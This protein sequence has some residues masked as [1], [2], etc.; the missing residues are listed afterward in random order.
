MKSCFH[1]AALFAAFALYTLSQ[2]P[3]R[4]DI[5]RDA[6]AF[7]PA[8]ASANA[9]TGQQLVYT[10]PPA[11]L[12]QARKLYY[13]RTALDFVFPLWSILALLAILTLGW[14]AR[15]R[16]W[17]A[18]L[19]AKKWLQ[20]LWFAPL[21]LLLLALL[22]L[23]PALVAHHVSLRY[24]QSIQ[25]WPSWFIDWIKG[26]AIDLVSGTFVFGVLFAIIRRSRRWWLWFWIVSLPTQ[27]FV[28]FVLPVVIDPIFNHF[29]PLAETNPELVVQLERVV[30][31]AGVSIPPSRMFLMKASEKVTGS[32]AYVTGFGASKRVVV[33]DTTIKG[34]PTGEILSIFGHEL[35]HYVLNHIQRGLL[36][37]SALSL[38][39]LWLGSHLA[40]FLVRRWGAR[41]GIASLEDWGAAALLL[42]VLAVLNLLVD[43][44]SNSI[45]RLQE[46]QADVFGLEV[47]HGLV[48]DPQRTAAQ[49]FQRLGEESLDYPNPNPF[50]VFWTYNHPS[51]AAREAFA[52]SYDPWKPG[53][54]PRYFKDR[55]GR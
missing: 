46:H 44:I 38:F 45:S 54:R 16:D 24:G 36:I 12:A 4:A 53:G 19:S 10:L 15:L 8:A 47:I 6:P 55:Q 21:L 3:A 39:F 28:I 29:E 9:A 30:A 2:T 31:K 26:L 52:E 11:K 20:G 25:H 48:A 33:W 18:S 32:N 41:W 27:V 37:G 35:G 43:P 23:P 7:E 5:Q 42:L 40:E 13:W 22:N 49:S 34:S 17:A 50:V 1:V 51:I 14:A